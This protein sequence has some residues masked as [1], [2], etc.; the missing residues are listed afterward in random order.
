MLPYFN[1]PLNGH[2]I[3]VWFYSLVKTRYF[4]I[5]WW[6]YRVVLRQHTKFDLIAL[7]H[8]HNNPQGD[9]SLH[10]NIFSLSTCVFLNNCVCLAKKQNK[11]WLV[12]GLIRSGIKIRIY[13][14]RT[15]HTN[16]YTNKTVNCL[17][18]REQFYRFYLIQA[19]TT[20]K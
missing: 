5:W 19:D 6:R 8:W 11:P 14:T 7:T 15:D 1:V 12:F 9:L 10:C 2:I 13:S 16:R 18:S 20:T 4:L 3:Q 17:I